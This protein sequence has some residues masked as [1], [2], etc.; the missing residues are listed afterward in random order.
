MAIMIVFA[1]RSAR[2]LQE[3]WWKIFC[4]VMTWVNLLPTRPC[5]ILPKWLTDGYIEY[6]AE[7]WSPKW[8]DDLK[9]ALAFGRL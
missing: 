8:D 2:A 1:C 5:L 7:Q 9:S 6:A 4:L 3:Y